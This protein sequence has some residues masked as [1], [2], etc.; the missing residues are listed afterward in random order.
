[1]ES[2]TVGSVFGTEAAVVSG[3]LACLVGLAALA[4]SFRSF[5]R[6]DARDPV[7]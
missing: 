2:G 5:A 7:P 1:V 6:Y 3:G 4:A